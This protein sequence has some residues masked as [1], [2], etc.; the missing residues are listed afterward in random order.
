M[1][2]ALFVGCV[3]DVFFPG[4]A[5]ATARILHHLGVEVVFP[6]DQTCC[7]QAHFNA[8]R[9]AEAAGF[10]RHFLEVFDEAGCDGV[11]APTG[12]CVA[13]VRH[14]HPAL[15]ARWPGLQDRA[16]RLAARTYEFAQFVTEVLGVTDLG[17]RYRAVAA[18]HASCHASRLLGAAGA[19]LRLLQA[20]QGLELRPVT[21]GERCCGFGGTFSVTSPEVSVAMADDR[22]DAFLEAG[23]QLVV[24]ADGSCL[25]HL[26]GRAHRRALPLRFMHVAELLARGMGLL[27]DGGG[28]P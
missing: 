6:P 25:L 12:S 26:M 13:M 21:G 10:A 16:R 28:R 2:V 17:A 20:V 15:L 8:G 5:V 27:E 3:N 18:Y 14:Q 7:G 23:A 19:P 24:S 9:W 22:L 4:A 11:V 1:R